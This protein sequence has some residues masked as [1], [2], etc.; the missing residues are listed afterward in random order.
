MT[1]KSVGIKAGSM[2]NRIQT[3]EPYS[4]VRGLRHGSVPEAPQPLAHGPPGLHPAVGL[5]ASAAARRPCPH[6]ARSS[7]E[8]PPHWPR[9]LGPPTTPF[10]SA[11]RAPGLVVARLRPARPRAPSKAPPTHRLLVPPPKDGHHGRSSAAGGKPRPRR[12]PGRA[13]RLTQQGTG[14]GAAAIAPR[15]SGP[16]SVSAAPTPHPPLRRLHPRPSPSASE[17]PTAVETRTQA[18]EGDSHSSGCLFSGS[19]PAPH[20]GLHTAPHTPLRTALLRLAHASNQRRG[21]SRP[22]RIA[23]G[24]RGLARGRH[25]AG[26]APPPRPASS[27]VPRRVAFPPVAGTRELQGWFRWFPAGGSSLEPWLAFPQL[28]VTAPASCVLLSRAVVAACGS[29]P[30]LPGAP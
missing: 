30:P 25:G 4:G 15:S 29:Q 7:Q 3:P 22:I 10:A 19:L 12:Q 21:L 6:N 23:R 14:Q 11:P 9:A 28:R 13:P 20:A 8:F 1:K 5:R 26:R 18:Q 16:A 2:E 17:L 24:E 27:A